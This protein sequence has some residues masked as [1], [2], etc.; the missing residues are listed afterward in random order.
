[1][2]CASSIHINLEDILLC[3]LQNVKSRP[4]CLNRCF[5]CSIQMLVVINNFNLRIE[6]I[7]KNVI[8]IMYENHGGYYHD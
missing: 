6:I 4:V 7:L 3:G 1:M 2:V 8:M 5:A